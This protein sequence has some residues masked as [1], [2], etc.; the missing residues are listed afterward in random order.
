VGPRRPLARVAEKIK[1]WERQ[2]RVFLAAPNE[3]HAAR[4]RE[5]LEEYGVERVAYLVGPLSRGFLLEQE[6]ILILTEEEIFGERVHPP[7]P[8][9]RSRL[10]QLVS[11][12]H[13]LRAGDYVVHVEHG[14]A[15]YLGLQVLKYGGLEGDFL[16]LRFEGN[17]R[18][19]VPPDQIDLVQK[20][21][22]PEGYR[23]R[24]DRLG[25]KAWERTKSNARKALREMAQELL[26]LYA[27]RQVVE[28]HGFAP[29][30]ALSREFD[31]AFEYEETPDQLRAIEEVKADMEAAR[32][33]DRIVCGDVGYGKTE[34]AMRA[35]FKA[36]LDNKQVAVLVPT[37]ILAQQHWQTF[38]DRFKAF[39]VTV[40]MLSRFRSPKEQRALLR[41][42]A[43]GGVDIVIGT[44]RLLQQDVRFHDLGLVV[45]DEEHRFGV[46]HKETLKQIRKQ[47]DVLTL[48]ATPIPRTLHMSLSGI[49]DLS[50]IETPPEDRLAIQTFVQ[51]FDRKVVRE[52]I[53]RELEREGQCY[54]VHNRVHSIDR[55]AVFLQDLVPEV[56]FAVAHGQMREAV[57]EKAM[58]RFL[59]REVDVLVTTTI[60]ES[61]LDIPT[62]NTILIHHAERFGLAQLYQLRGRVGRSRYRA[63]AYLLVSE[64]KLL[65]EEARQRLR[66]LQELSELG[67]GFQI[68]A[69]DLEIRGAGNILGAAQ[70]GHMAAI[71]F[72]LYYQL[73]EQ[74]IHEL[75]GE[76]PTE[77]PE[78][79]LNLGVSAY[80]PEAFIPDIS[81]RLALYKRIAAGREEAELDALR[82]EIRDRFGPLPP[83]ALAILEVMGIKI[84]AR[85]LGLSRIDV[86]PPWAELRWQETTL[87]DPDRLIAWAQAEPRRVQLL[88]EGGMR[89]RLSSADRLQE[90]K[91]SLQAV[92]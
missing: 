91:K 90:L 12:F 82:E 34:V 27:A 89:L 19:Y 59:R 24:L 84:H 21:T 6:R 18:L 25:G 48:T 45:V 63:F 46:A 41:K 83:P 86:R 62:A 52:A 92:G 30:S 80:L 66:T 26:D 55:I 17:D 40:E 69:R 47:V 57:L 38:T 23:P 81:Q 56:R 5:I 71:G 53:L 8:P 3:G 88:P 31:A 37:T 85:R 9:K 22:G 13:A 51:R 61:G 33:M 1:G 35:A 4:L 10:S 76:V 16:V 50:V 79:T 36:V 58:L 68:A 60:I 72:E 14:I 64:G 2:Y 49:R 77:F 87:M 44:H 29:D 43:E 11:T 20:H 70:S 54:F 15:E 32:P 74:A 78:P 75:K 7:S 73:L 67:A 65:S 42:A 39:P 28:G